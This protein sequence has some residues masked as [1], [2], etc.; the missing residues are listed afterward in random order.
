MSWDVIDS[1]TFAALLGTAVFAASGAL[2]GLRKGMDVVGVSFVATVTG[3]GGGTIRDL[4]L[5]DTP[6][7]W[8]QNPVDILICVGVAVLL[9][10]VHRSLVGRRMD[11]LLYAD[12]AGLA[13]F[14]VLGAQK[15]ESLGAH[16]VS[17]VIFGAMTATFGGIIRDVMCNETPVLFRKE[18]YVSSALL[19]SGLYTLSPEALGFTLRALLGMGGAFVLRLAALRWQ[20]SLPFPHYRASDER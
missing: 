9:C 5:G 11:A 19:G 15:A 14:C 3:I 6:V 4:L 1:L 13:L 8:V 18:I 7:G 20:W 16:P 2:L 10:L 12:A 17:I